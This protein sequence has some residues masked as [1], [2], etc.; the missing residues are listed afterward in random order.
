MFSDPSGNM[1]KNGAFVI[2]PLF[3]ALPLVN[4]EATSL[5][6]RAGHTGVKFLPIE[7]DDASDNL[8]RDGVPKAL[9]GSREH[10]FQAGNFELLF[11]ADIGVEIANIRKWGWDI[12]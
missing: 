2:H 3:A 1:L 12:Q 8:Q 11:R 6:V 7:H 5:I 4:M 10:A 9:E